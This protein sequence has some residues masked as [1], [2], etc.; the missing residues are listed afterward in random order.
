MLADGIADLPAG[1]LPVHWHPRVLS[2]RSGAADF[3]QQPIE[4]AQR[5]FDWFLGWNDL[6]WELS[7]NRWLPRWLARGPG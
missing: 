6:G 1:S 3:D 2:G 4:Q 5:A 7:Q